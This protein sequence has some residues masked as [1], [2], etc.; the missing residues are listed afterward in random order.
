[1]QH[2]R[3]FENCL[4]DTTTAVEVSTAQKE[5]VSELLERI[6]KNCPAVVENCRG[7]MYLGAA[8]IG[9]A[10]YHVAKCP[11]FADK[12]NLFL[13]IAESYVKVAVQEIDKVDPLRG[14]IGASL[15]LGHAG[16]YC[17]AILVYEALGQQAEKE[18]YLQSFLKMQSN[19]SMNSDEFFMGRAGYLAACL[20]LNKHLKKD[21]I[22]NDVTL[23][24]C[25]LTIE[26]G[27]QYSKEHSHPSPLM[28][29]YY[30]AECLGAGHGLARILLALLNFPECY[31]D[32][33]LVENDIKSSIDYILTCEQ[34]NGN[35]PMVTSECRGDED[36][37]VHWC[38]GAPGVIYVL[39]KAFL[40]WK[41]EKYLSA[42]MRCG[43]L[44]WKRGLLRKG[45]GLC[46]GIAGN[47]YPFLL[48]YRLTSN[49]KYLHRA[50]EF[51]A[52]METKEFKEN[53]RVPDAP[54]SL[55]EGIAGTA[56]YLADLTN[57]AESMFPFVDIF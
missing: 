54:Y 56:C 36:E 4:D 51:A 35:Y 42:A 34:E 15:L 17:T 41:D 40:V 19:L 16:V 44:I 8:G 3:Y 21:S 1:M 32:N 12:R 7:A 50:R 26:S 38:H 28:Y 13:E 6:H 39:A 10:F 57:P 33:P 14:G 43:E 46:H 22:P 31:V 53:S 52:F 29:A 25:N 49:E 37:L 30:T 45:P 9:Y 18:E 20:M 47:G 55:F 27:R 11:K 5:C 48:L 2:P 23:Q 24:L